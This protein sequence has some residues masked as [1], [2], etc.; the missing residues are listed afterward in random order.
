M[1][2]NLNLQNLTKLSKLDLVAWRSGVAQLEL[3]LA[4]EDTQSQDKVLQAIRRAM[5]T[6]PLIINWTVL[7][8]HPEVPRFPFDP[9]AYQALAALDIAGVRTKFLL[10]SETGA[11][12]EDLILPEEVKMLQEARISR[13]KLEVLCTTSLL[14]SKME[15]FRIAGTPSLET[16]LKSI[17]RKLI[18]HPT[19]ISDKVRVRL[20]EDI[21]IVTKGQ[22]TQFPAPSLSTC[23]AALVTSRVENV[24][25]NGSNAVMVGS[26]SILSG[27]QVEKW[28]EEVELVA[29]S[30]QPATQLDPLLT[31]RN[32]ILLGKGTPYALPDPSMHSKS[33]DKKNSL[34][35]SLLTR[36][37][38]SQAEVLIVWTR[39]DLYR[40]YKDGPASRG[41]TK[42]YYAL[43]ALE[44]GLLLAKELLNAEMITS[45]P[46]PH[47]GESDKSA[48]MEAREQELLDLEMNVA[49]DQL[50]KRDYVA[51]E[52]SSGVAEALETLIWTSSGKAHFKSL[53]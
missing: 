10:L 39:W 4:E 2:F 41:L 21:L 28:H 45:P 27:V 9:K 3:D 17:A 1:R 22:L 26:T 15:R 51:E 5:T 16:Y 40:L 23:Q 14:H 46:L 25:Q 52:S 33:E 29:L 30:T 35:F 18:K 31:G 53:V 49:L 37:L 13:A 50:P 43:M 38:S 12:L 34:R 47:G 8:I 32:A 42:R 6:L 44:N 7:F 36:K 11:D 20:A 19:K 48:P 24:V